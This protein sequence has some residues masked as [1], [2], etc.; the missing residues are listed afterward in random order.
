LGFI[1]RIPENKV[2]ITDDKLPFS[3][4]IPDLNQILKQIFG[5]SNFHEG[6][7]EAICSFLEYRDTLVVL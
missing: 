6:Q 2:Q 1:Q 4:H 5:F 7:Y 3:S